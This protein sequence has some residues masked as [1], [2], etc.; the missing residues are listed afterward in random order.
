MRW[1]FFVVPAMVAAVT[2]ITP[3]RSDTQKHPPRNTQSDLIAYS[4]IDKAWR[5][6]RGAGGLVAVVDWQFDMGRPASEKYA[7][8]VSLVPGEEIGAMKPWHGEWMAEIVH[9]VA[10]DAKVIPINARSLKQRDYQD[11]L[12]RAIRYAADHGAA[13]VTSSMGPTRQ[14]PELLAAVAYAEQRGTLFIDVH[15]EVIATAGATPRPC[16][17]GECD[18]RIVRTGIVSVP[19]HPSRSEPTRDVYTWPYDLVAHYQ[20]GWGYS[21][22]P[23]TVGGVVALVRSAN[24][25]LSPAQVK[26]LLVRTAVERDGFRVLDAEAAVKAARR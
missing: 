11:C 16:G 13:A 5:L 25:A 20:D 21:N 14:T 19:D 3:S 22:A 24:P 18:P 26:A 15:P 10:P 8:A 9:R 7:H 17:I 1:S 2:G 4:N 23:P 12:V 6:S